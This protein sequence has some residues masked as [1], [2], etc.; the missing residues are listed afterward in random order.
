MNIL[1]LLFGKKSPEA[2]EQ[3]SRAGNIERVSIIIKRLEP[4]F[5][6]EALETAAANGHLEIVKILLE[7]GVLLNAQPLYEAAKAGHFEVVQHLL[8]Y[9][10]AVN[11]EMSKN[12]NQGLRGDDSIYRCTPLKAAASNGHIEIVKLL[13]TNGADV[14]LA[15]SYYGFYSPP[16]GPLSDA[17]SSGN[18]EIVK[19]LL[20]SGALPD[21][22][23]ASP[24]I[25]TAARIGNI[26]MLKLL[27]EAGANINSY[28]KDDDWRPTQALHE[29]VE[30][31]HLSV[32]I[33]LLEN[34]ADINAS[35]GYLTG[36]PLDIAYSNGSMKI[37]KLLEERGA[38][39]SK[40]S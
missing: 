34:G 30:K 17:V 23:K 19:F 3:A 11:A 36:T 33:F 4:G 37:I 38:I 16:T 1:F 22:T 9:G 7:H 31:K 25:L 27:L 5:C 6:I 26:K 15:T 21:G 14:N 40:P 12:Y 32:I 13:I 2:L 29:A 20:M 35:G 24:P 28:I 10:A 8:K 18:I 39:R